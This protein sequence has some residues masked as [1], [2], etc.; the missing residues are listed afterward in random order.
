MRIRVGYPC[1]IVHHQPSQ[2]LFVLPKGREKESELCL[3][4][5][6]SKSPCAISSSNQLPNKVLA[7]VEHEVCSETCRLPM[8]LEQLKSYH[9][10]S[11]ASRRAKSA[12]KRR[13][14]GKHSSNCP[15]WFSPNIGQA[16][17]G[18]QTCKISRAQNPSLG[19]GSYTLW[20][21]GEVA[22]TLWL[23]SIA[24]LIPRP[25]FLFIELIFSHNK[26]ALYLV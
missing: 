5:E 17:R 21:S 3:V 1:N 2:P 15:S 8:S 19:P 23:N 7:R 22:H 14:A 26:K 24:A 20:P 6:R 13:E 10:S 4:F 9:N 12:V 18:V 11:N 16:C 25:Q